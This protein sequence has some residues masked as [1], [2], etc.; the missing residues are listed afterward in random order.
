MTSKRHLEHLVE[1][2]GTLLREVAKLDVEI[3]R[4]LAQ[5]KESA[6]RSS[7]NRGGHDPLSWEEALHRAKIPPYRRAFVP[8]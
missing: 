6:P 4:E 5:W 2:R 7:R 1:L 8:G 3:A